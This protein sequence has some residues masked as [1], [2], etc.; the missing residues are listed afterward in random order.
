M[1]KISV[2]PVVRG[3][4]RFWTNSE[5]I[6]KA[7]SETEGNVNE[8]IARAIER[9]VECREQD[10]CLACEE[11]NE[12]KP[13]CVRTGRFEVSRG[14]DERNVFSVDKGGKLLG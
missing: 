3:N 10:D 5:E 6:A 1:R 13:S 14:P 7:I 11:K 9:Q 8:N 4:S 12:V 2:P